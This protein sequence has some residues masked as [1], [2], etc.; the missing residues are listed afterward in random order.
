M[1]RNRGALAGVLPSVA[2]SR[3]PQYKGAPK[4]H[5]P[6]CQLPFDKAKEPGQRTWHVACVKEYEAQSPTHQRRLVRQRDAGVCAICGLDTLVMERG[7]RAAFWRAH[8]DEWRAA[9]RQHWRDPNPRTY[10]PA[11][12]SAS[13]RRFRAAPLQ[14]RGFDPRRRS[15]VDVDHV[16]ELQDGGANEL[17]NLQNL[18]SPCHKR[19]TA[20]LRRRR[21]KGKPRDRRLLGQ[22][23]RL[24]GGGVACLWWDPTGQEVVAWHR[25][26]PTG[27][28]G[29]KVLKPG[30]GP[31]IRHG[32]ET[33]S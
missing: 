18:C 19:K 33:R 23:V 32:E 20:L 26:R 24:P 7:L 16:V 9:C 3:K 4:G 2:T 1:D 28:L 27:P 14:R 21:A 12:W 30:P 17:A 5:C 13:W 6:W 11:R 25:G 15:L 29:Q 8:P 10:R 22:C 31:P